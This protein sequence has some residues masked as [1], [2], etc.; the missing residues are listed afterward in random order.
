[1]IL[2]AMSSSRLHGLAD[3]W[4]V[5]MPDIENKRNRPK[6]PPISSCQAISPDNQWLE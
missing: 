4:R 1:M 2:L 5:L 3:G 6:T